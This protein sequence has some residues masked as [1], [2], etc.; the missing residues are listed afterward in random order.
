MLLRKFL[1]CCLL[2][3]PVAPAWAEPVDSVV[4][5][6][7]D[8]GGTSS[9]LLNRMSK[10][11][12][13]VA[14]QLFIDKDSVNINA[15]RGDYEHLLAEV[16]DRVL[17]GYQME[18]VSVNA[19][20]VTSIDMRVAPWSAAVENVFVDLQ[21][22]GVEAGTAGLLKKRLPELQER[23]EY[24]I[25]GSSVDA[26][27]WAGGILRRLV[28]SEVEEKLPEF[29]AAVDVVREDNRTVV[30]VVIYPVGQLV[31]N[32]DYSMTSESIPNLLLLDL[33]QRYAEKA[34]A[35]RGL[36]VEYV[37]RHQQELESMLL[38]DLQNEKS[39]RLHNLAPAVKLVPGSTLGVEIG[40]GSDKYKI[41]F[42]GYGDIG[43]N[44]DN[45][46]GRA[47]IGKFISK[48]DE[49]FGEA[50]V[51][52]DD[53]EWDFSAGY[54]R[55]WGKATLSYMRR[56]P[57][58]QNVFRGEYDFTSKWRLRTEYFSG[59]DTTEIAV[60]YRI[61][62]FLSAE[63]VYSNDKPYFRIVGNL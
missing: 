35:L 41:W 19:G 20:A 44:E 17:T 30:Q 53:V 37:K 55:H 51:T 15:A 58:G 38:T 42:E 40:M 62:E 7:T 49:I 43:R 12:Q 54:A 31:Q 14:E 18:S 47:H 26:N 3:L 27:D 36:P 61:H 6:I 13:V 8:N 22:S 28:R 59:T 16:G 9:V 34:E 4:V 52:L 39:V 60:R 1:L 2:C 48:R 32:V 33:K 10:S 63:Y 56:S 46:S 29:K 21:F 45:I 57:D 23:I 24:I 25:K 50:G 5:H 11:M